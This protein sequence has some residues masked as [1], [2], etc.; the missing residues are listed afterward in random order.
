MSRKAKVGISTGNDPSKPEAAFLRAKKKMKE[1]M[2]V[3]WKDFFEKNPDIKEE[4]LRQRIEER[5]REKQ[6]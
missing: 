6:K 5:L 3:A 2:D 4:D 1:Q